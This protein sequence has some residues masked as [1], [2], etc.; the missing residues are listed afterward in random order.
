MKKKNVVR[1]LALALCLVFT[2]SACGK[3]PLE[4][5]FPFD[6][7]FFGSKD[8]EK[9]EKE[10]RERR[11]V[12]YAAMNYERPDMDA[13]KAEMLDMTKALEAV[14]SFDELMDLDD[15]VG[16]LSEQFNTMHT[17]ASLKKYH[18][19]TDTY[20]EEEYRFLEDAGVELTTLLNNYNRVIVDGPYAKQ[21]EEEVGSYVYQS[22]LDSLLLDSESVQKYKKER[23]QLNADYNKKLATLKVTYEGEEY[24]VEDLYSADSAAMYAQLWDLLYNQNAKEFTEMYARMIELD[25]QTAFEL[26]FNSPAEM[27][28]LSYS[29]DY[30]VDDALK[31]CENVKKHIVPL[32]PLLYGNLYE[33][34]EMPQ[35]SAFAGMPGALAEVDGELSEAWDF[36]LEY[37]MYDTDPLPN[38]QSGIGFTTSIPAYDTP[39]IFMSWDD[40]LS[41][42]T[43]LTHEF[44]HFYDFW[45]HYDDDVVFNLDVAET[46]SQGLELLMHDLYGNFTGTANADEEALYNAQMASLQG[47]AANTLIYQCVLEEFQ[48]RAYELDS[49]DSAILGRLYAEVLAEYGYG[50]A[51]MPDAFGADNS[52]FSVTHVFDSPFYTISYVT[53]ATAA[54]QIWALGQDNWNSAVDTYLEMIRADQNQPFSS[55]LK[56]VGLKPP[57]DESV[58]K[59]IAE[60]FET[61][62]SEAYSNAA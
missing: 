31:L 57:H 47:M 26:G 38:K 34:G 61:V 3:P 17:L 44:G 8:A 1:L 32:L 13:L 2:L 46:Y 23:A 10:K 21:Y 5:D 6:L 60:D 15:K 11:T 39:F 20:F 56:E 27:Y 18:D 42:L 24:T 40:G 16:E 37:G 45:L 25:K 14:H 4:F 29:R 43:T 12:D 30:S 52:W 36:M 58:M 54:L 50:A 48:I 62:F 22:I 9:P 35:D 33:S 49:F 41:S 28:Y 7:P 19:A 55:L 51:V 59:T 53:S